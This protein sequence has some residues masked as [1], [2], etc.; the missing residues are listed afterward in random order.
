MTFVTPASPEA[1]AALSPV[2]MD[3][4]IS[5]ATSRTPNDNFGNTRRPHWPEY[6]PQNQVR[7]TH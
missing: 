5:F 6:T 3:Y 2:I 7:V 1:F 4:W